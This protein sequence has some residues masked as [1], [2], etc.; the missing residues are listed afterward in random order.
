MI[1]LLL[2]LLLFTMSLL[3]LIGLIIGLN[4]PTITLVNLTI[5]DFQ[6]EKKFTIFTNILMFIAVILVTIGIYFAYYIIR[7]PSI[8]IFKWLFIAKAK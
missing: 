6:F 2:F 5:A 1:D 3:V 8:A 7:I 4:E